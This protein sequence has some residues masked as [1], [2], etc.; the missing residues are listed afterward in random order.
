MPYDPTFDATVHVYLKNAE[1]QTF[2]A[3][4]DAKTVDEAVSKVEH[5]IREATG[6][7]TW[8]AFD[9]KVF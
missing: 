6:D 8:E 2:T 1:G 9:W 4:R 7:T 3:V 5:E